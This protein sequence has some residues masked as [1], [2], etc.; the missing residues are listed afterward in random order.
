METFGTIHKF[1]FI[2]SACFVP[3]YVLYF[4]WRIYCLYKLAGQ[5]VESVGFLWFSW[6]V[7]SPGFARSDKV[8]KA[9][10]EDLQD[11]IATFQSNARRAHVGIVLW[12]FSLILFAVLARRIF[13]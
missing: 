7:Q 8:L 2:V 6:H 11:K 10:P 12:I 1:V 5:Q 3:C 9:L 13:S 4:Y